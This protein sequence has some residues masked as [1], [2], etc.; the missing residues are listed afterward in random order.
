KLVT[1]V[2]TCAL[3]ISSPLLPPLSDVPENGVLDADLSAAV[4]QAKATL[5]G[6]DAAGAKQSLI[7]MLS[8]NDRFTH[9]QR[10]AVAQL[11]APVLRSEERRV[12]KEC[13]AR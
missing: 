13:R 3:P 9:A 12:G 7:S 5:D 11:A 1:G 8:S 10:A 6:G 2:Q 4:A